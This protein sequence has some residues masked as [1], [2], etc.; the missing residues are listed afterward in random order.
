MQTPESWGGLALPRL[1]VMVLPGPLCLCHPH[2]GFITGWQA[3]LQGSRPP[4]L[5]A[6]APSPAATLQCLRAPPSQTPRVPATKALEGFMAHRT[7]GTCA[8]VVLHL[9]E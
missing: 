8:G 1:L 5:K 3:H 2:Q 9:F 7:P 6:G 4:P